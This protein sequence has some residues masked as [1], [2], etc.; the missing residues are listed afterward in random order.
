MTAI[1]QVTFDPETNTVYAEPDEMLDQHRRYALVVMDSVRDLSDDPVEADPRFSSCLASPFQSQYCTRL[2]T[3]LSTLSIPGRVVAASLFT[4]MSATAWLEKARQQIQTSPI[5]LQRA[6]PRSTFRVS[7]LATLTVRF[8]VR[9]NP[10]EFEDFVVPRPLLQLFL[11][12]VDR[13]WFGSFSSPSFLDDQQIIPTLPTGEEVALPQKSTDVLFHAVL[14]RSPKP[15]AGHPVVIFGHGLGDSRFGAPTLVSNIFARNGFATVAINAV[16]HGSGPAGTVHL[17]EMDGTT[18]V[19]SAGG[20][21]LDLNGDGTIESREGCLLLESGPFALRDCLR[22]TALDLMQL[23]RLIR[24]GLD[25]DG[26]GAVDL[27]PDRV[28]YG[29]QS[30][31][32]LYGTILT[33]VEP[34]IRSAALNVGG[35]S[36]V[37][38]GRWSQSFRSLARDFFAARTPPLL[39]ANG[40]FDENYVLRNQ[41][42]K[43]NAVAGAIEIQNVFDLAEWL[44][45]RGDPLAYAPHLRLSPLPGVPEKRVLWQFAR[46]DRT[47]PNPQNSGLIRAAGMRESSQLYR[48]DLARAI[49]SQLPENPHSFLAEI[50]STLGFA[51]AVATQQQMAGF[52]AT[53][54]AEIPDTNSLVRVIFGRKI[55]ET[56]T[57]LPED[58]GFGAEVVNASA[59]SFDFVVAPAS[60]VTAGGEHLATRTESAPETAL[61]TALAGTT[62][63]VTD[64]TGIERSAQLFFVSPRQVNY[65]IPAG[66][67]AGLATV[68][69]ASGDGLVSTGTAQV[70]AV[71]PSLFSANASGAGI[72]A[73]VALRVAADGS[74]STELVFRCNAGL[75]TCLPV[76]VDLGP[77]TERVFLMLFGTGIRGRSSMSAVSV[78]IGSESVPVTYAGPQPEYEGLDQVNVGPLPR[79]LAGRGTVEILLSVDNRTANIVTMS[80]F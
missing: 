21:S 29:G 34:S 56:P 52:F 63:S 30:L 78:K 2:A 43:I 47:V 27:D 57:V 4:T 70:E 59:A 20:R 54:G 7:D 73:A 36:V 18:T 1:N 16:G 74:R 44:Q 37:N 12:D 6:A 40:D 5:N 23:V 46:G 8:Q 33:S 48:H 39:N 68:K 13:V 28:Y 3:V 69:V 79:T 66:T 45:M 80:V 60:I 55:F 17:L 10:A 58:L 62:V 32:A 22:Q 49:I 35:G 64:I 77:E 9:A 51:V 26:D 15:A 25:L 75:G 67:A 19:L 65:V 71:A 50:E 76:P 38:I 31:G 61:P 41:P 11:P 42:V 72:A 24:R 14:P 53:D